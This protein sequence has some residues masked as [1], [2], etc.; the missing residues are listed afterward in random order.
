MARRV[1]DPSS[2]PV[3][4]PRDLEKREAILDA[5]WRT[6]LS[7]GVQGAS[8]EAVARAAGVSRVT[9]YSHFA[10]KEALFEAAI[11]REM[12]RLAATQR[13]LPEG[14]S[15]RDGLIAFGAG[16]MAYL[17]S[18]DAVN[19]Y[20]VLAGELRRHPDLARSFFNLGPGVTRKNLSAILAVASAKRELDIADADE[21]A[22]HL[23]GLWQGLSNFELALGLNSELQAQATT[24]RVERAV[25]VFLV[26]YSRKERGRLR[27]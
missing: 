26:A 27:G 4:R 17:T 22:E 24:K 1:I 6:F 16:L 11:R 10:D 19:F 5:G 2:R 21:A 8:L 15:L 13:P 12:E 3:G 23:I 9:L 14:V 25:D 7:E 20:S 18:P